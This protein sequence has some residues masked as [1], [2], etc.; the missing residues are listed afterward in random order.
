M[1]KT[2]LIRH[3]DGKREIALMDGKRLLHFGHDEGGGIAAEQIYLGRVDRIVKG[4]EAAFV[5]LG[6]DA[7]GFLPF[8]EC[9]E[10]PRSGDRIIVQVKK[11]PVGERPRI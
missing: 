2:I 7:I 6:G 8:S 5:K 3:L 9:R 4:M 11:P 10:K 1:S